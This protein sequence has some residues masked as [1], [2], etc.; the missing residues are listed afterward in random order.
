MFDL[1]RRAIPFFYIV[2][3]VV[4]FYYS[5]LK[6]TKE[7]EKIFSKIIVT[8]VIGQVC[9]HS[10]FIHYRWEQYILLEKDWSCGYWHYYGKS[11]SDTYG[12]RDELEEKEAK[13][14]IKKMMKSKKHYEIEVTGLNDG[15][16]VSTNRVILGIVRS[17]KN[18]KVI[19]FEEGEE[20]N[21]LDE[22]LEVGMAYKTSRPLTLLD[23]GHLNRLLKEETI[24]LSWKLNNPLE[25]E[26][27]AEKRLGIT[28]YGQGGDTQYF[29]K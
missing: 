29:R 17:K 2:T 10:L 20:I 1:C 25:F 27:E 19:V 24:L 21:L 23:L 26:R 6:K 15:D 28:L 5:K 9:A 11:E 13:K 22:K 8:L 18:D 3:I 16:L 14:F 12:S 7:N 4:I